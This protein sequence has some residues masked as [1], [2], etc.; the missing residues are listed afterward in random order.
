MTE[1]K[2]NAFMLHRQMAMNNGQKQ[3]TYN[4]NIYYRTITKTGLETFKKRIPRK[5]KTRTKK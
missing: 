3:F 4:G 2:N 5:K 1:I